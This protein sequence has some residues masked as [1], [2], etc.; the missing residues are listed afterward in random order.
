MTRLSK[1]KR[2]S[3]AAIGDS[4]VIPGERGSARP[5]I[6]CLCVIPG[7]R[8]SARPGIQCLCVIPGERGSARPGILKSLMLER[9]LAFLDE[10]A[11]ALLLVFEREGRVKLAPLEEEPFGER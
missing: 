3:L 5:G 6:Q 8:G 1:S 7:E 4:R 10:S 11:H 9:R 2:R